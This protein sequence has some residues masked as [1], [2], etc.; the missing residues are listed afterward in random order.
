M[1]SSYYLFSVSEQLKIF[2]HEIREYILDTY[3]LDHNNH[4]GKEGRVLEIDNRDIDNLVRTKDRPMNSI[5]RAMLIAS[6]EH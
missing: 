6:R 2:V 4:R 5:E 1:R 3:S